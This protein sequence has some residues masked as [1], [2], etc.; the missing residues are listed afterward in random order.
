MR[1]AILVP[2]LC[3]A[4]DPPKFTVTPLATHGLRQDVGVY[5]LAIIRREPQPPNVVNHIL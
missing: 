1:F 3:L 5:D 2:L 4:Q